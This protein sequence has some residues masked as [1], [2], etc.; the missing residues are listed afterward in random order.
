MEFPMTIAVSFRGVSR[1]Y[2]Q[3]RAVDNVDVEIVEV[4]NATEEE[5]AHGHAH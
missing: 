4:R 2:G 3:V 1:H 5:I